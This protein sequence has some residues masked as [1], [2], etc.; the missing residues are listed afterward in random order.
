[1]PPAG[2]GLELVDRA[3]GDD[4]TAGDD[5]DVFAHVLDEVELMAAEDD[6][7]ARRRP[8][9]DDLGHG[10]DADR[11]EAAEGLVEHEQLGI[12]GERGRQL[13][14]LLVAVRQ[15]LELGLGPVAEAHPLQPAQGG[16][17]RRLAT[18]A[19]LLGEVRELLGDAHPRIQPALLGHIAE[20]KTLDAIDGL[21][22]PA[23]LAAIRPGQAEDAAHR[24]GLAGAIRSEESD[25]PP[26]LGGE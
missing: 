20:A 23:D 5:D 19:V 9:A 15:L 24:G 7:H 2:A 10:R 25:D 26:G 17:I 18:E 8:L 13:D 22:G 14:A 16:G 21:S 12:V 1:M 4:P 6:A 11:I 3:R